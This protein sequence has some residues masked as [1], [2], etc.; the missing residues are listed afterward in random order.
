MLE[1]SADREALLAAADAT[2]DGVRE[3]AAA[4]GADGKVTAQVHA[5]LRDAR[6]FAAFLPKELGGLGTDPVTLLEIVERVSAQD[7]STGWCL[8]HNGMIGGFA[9]T[10]LP[11]AGAREVFDEWGSVVIAGGYVP[12]C[13]A[14]AVAGGYEVSGRVPF[15]SGCRNADSLLVTGIVDGVE[16]SKAMRSFVI[17]PSEVTVLD[18]WQV[19]GLEGTSSNDLEVEAVFVPEA[20]SFA[21]MADAP[22]RGA[23]EWRCP[24]L[25]FAAVA[26]LGFAL[27]VASHA[28]EEIA[29][30]AGRQ[31]IGS[32]QAISKRP[33]F[34]RG[35]G[36]ARVQLRAA[37][38]GGYA[39][40]EAV[41]SARGDASLEQRAELAAAM[42]H[43]Y[44][45]ATEIAEFAF[46][47]GGASSLYDTSALQR[48]FR[49]AQAGAQHIVA[50]EEAYERAGGVFLGGDDPNFI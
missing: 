1:R 22:L 8:G 13:R 16:G 7:G 10:R 2:A 47:N 37:R 36:R 46:R 6:F 4:A 12:R 11:E 35:F 27:G 38:L 5:A 26:H 33:V 40:F 24:I 30:H 48:C 15:A 42:A 23:A 50:S 41:I 25:S 34:Q 3:N 19:L 9:A 49:D 31:R 21:P 39:A 17:A 32:T 20:R 18:N 28:L 45:V 43:C 44:E 29:A 14:Q